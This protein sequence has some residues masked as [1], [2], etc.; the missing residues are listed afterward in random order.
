[1]GS[2]IPRLATTFEVAGLYVPAVGFGTFQTGEGGR[3]VKEVVVRALQNGYTHIDTAVGYGNEE[4]VG[5]A[6]KES[7]INR[8]KLFITT[9]L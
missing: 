2:D 9:K 6:I 8:E 1:M 4:E 3:S 5:Q 7:G